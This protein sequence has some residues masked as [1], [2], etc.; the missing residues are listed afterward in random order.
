[1]FIRR[2]GD[3]SWSRSCSVRHTS[4]S[5]P[6]LAVGDNIASTP[7]SERARRKSRR[8]ASDGSE[9]VRQRRS[10][11]SG[12]NSGVGDKKQIATGD[13]DDDDDDD[14][15]AA[16]QQRKASL[17]GPPSSLIICTDDIYRIFRKLFPFFSGVVSNVPQILMLAI[18]LLHLRQYGLDVCYVT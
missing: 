18:D 1:L 12:S 16:D 7:P 2:T 11:S 8:S 3:K 9:S 5:R 13:D 6:I 14:E 17:Q 10:A 4:S 15:M